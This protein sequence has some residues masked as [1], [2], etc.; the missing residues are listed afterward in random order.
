V[1]QPHP[2]SENG[3]RPGEAARPQVRGVFGGG[4]WEIGTFS[5]IQIAIDHSWVLIAALISFS[6]ASHFGMEYP[7]WGPIARWATA[8]V[9]SALFFLSL[10][11][12]ELGHSLTAQHLGVRVRSITLFLFGG[13][14]QLE[15]EP[16]RPRDEIAIAIAGPLVS[17]ALALLFGG[18]GSFAETSGSGMASEIPAG[19]LIWLGRI[20]FALALFNCLP[21]FP[22]DGGRV[23]R[24]I[25]WGITG[26]FERATRQ[27]AAT[28]SVVAYGLILLGIVAVLAGGQIISGLWLAFIGWF[29]LSAARSTVSQ[30]VLERV[31]SRVRVGEVAIRVDDVCIDP[32]TT[33]ESLVNEAVLGRGI[34]TFYVTDPDGALLGLISLP[35]LVGVRPEA[36]S[37]TRAEEIMRPASQLTTIGA[38][39]NTWTAFM[40]MAKHG[41]NQLP[42]LEGRVLLGAVTRERLLVLVQGGIALEA[43]RLAESA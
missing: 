24:G 19:M 10:V 38:H 42:V 31:L 3:S 5:G 37:T 29:L 18:A 36:R 32:T 14:A 39:E 41:V 6:L 30:L 28:G 27:A 26:S 34:R 33:V 16:K 2:K 12:H 9:T 4:A 40:Q 43:P 25:V 1:S 20:N 17:L 8:L 21:G 15:S 22:L 7:A 35:E 23:L 13:V 11:L